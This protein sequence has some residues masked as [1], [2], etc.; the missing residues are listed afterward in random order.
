MRTPEKV[1]L[2]IDQPINYSTSTNRGWKRAAIVLG[3]GAIACL[4]TASVTPTGLCSAFSSTKNAIGNA[5]GSIVSHCG[6]GRIHLSSSNS[7]DLHKFCRNPQVVVPDGS[8]LDFMRSEEYRA[9]SLENL[10]A[11]LRVPSISRDDSGPPGE[12]PIWDT[13]SQVHEVLDNQYPLIRQ[14]LQKEVVNSFGLV[15]TWPGSEPDLKPVLFTAHLDVVPVPNDT[16]HKWTYPPF[17]AHFDGKDIWARGAADTKHSVTNV[18]DAIEALLEQGFTP[19]RTIVAGFGYDEESSGRYGA[20]FIAQHLK[21]RYG[22]DSP[23][24]SLVDEGGFGV[25]HVM[26]TNMAGISVAEKGRY[27]VEIKLSMIGGHSSIPPDHTAIGVMGDVA[28]EIEATPYEP[29]LNNPFLQYLQCVAVYSDDMSDGMRSTILN[30]NKSSIARDKLVGALHSNRMV[31]YIMQTSQ[32]I[33]IVRGGEKINAIP[34]MVTLAVD[35]RVAVHD[36]F[37]TIR[38]K[39]TGNVMKVAELYDLGVVSFGKELRKGAN[40]A[41]YFELEQYVVSPIVPAPVTPWNTDAWNDF[42]GVVRHVYEDFGGDIYDQE[43]G[44]AFPPKNVVVSPTLHT[45]NTDTQYYWDLTENI[46]RFTPLRPD[47]PPNYHTIDE[48]ISL[49][50][51]IEGTAVYYEY[52]QIV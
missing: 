23:F 25:V 7:A 10:Q 29:R 11:I 33:D 52:I 37:D 1:E 43:T 3:A 47:S 32:S 28:H 21:E 18:M 46:Y 5:A 42:A 41:E 6:G 2:G 50:A 13:F 22:T 9:R 44:E 45:P 15:Y 31:R 8:S 38:D 16:L 4:L 36:N 26:G 30:A 12:D 19:K 24:H 48:H 51:H 27:G 17:S 35:H 49:D 14:N 39:L 40:P 34:E 20:K